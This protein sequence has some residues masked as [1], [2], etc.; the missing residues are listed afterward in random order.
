M[1]QV[2]T[3]SLSYIVPLCFKVAC[4]GMKLLPRMVL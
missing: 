1:F 2:A 3:V 4:G